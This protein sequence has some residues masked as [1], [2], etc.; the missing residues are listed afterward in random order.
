MAIASGIR[1]SRHEVLRNALVEDEKEGWHMMTAGFVCG[2]D[3]YFLTTPL[4]FM[5]TRFQGNAGRELYDRNFLIE[6]IRHVSETGTLWSTEV[7][8]H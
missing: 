5:K 3:A 6:L 1:F 7:V 4:H 2:A 8:C